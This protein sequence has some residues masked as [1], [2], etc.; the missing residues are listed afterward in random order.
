MCY[1]TAWHKIP[2]SCSL[3]L[4]LMAKIFQFLTRISIYTF[5]DD[6]TLPLASKTTL[7]GLLSC[8]WRPSDHD[9]DFGKC[10]KIFRIL[11]VTSP[12][13]AAASA[14]PSVILLT[15]DQYL[16]RAPATQA[17]RQAASA[18]MRNGNGRGKCRITASYSH[19]KTK[20]SL[21]H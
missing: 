5:Q 6:F 11:F 14:F 16:L 7:L 12:K 21:Q 9:F 1:K 20:A 2:P 10:L 8:S 13:Q 18:W 15:G 19:R 4:F 17:S 3:H